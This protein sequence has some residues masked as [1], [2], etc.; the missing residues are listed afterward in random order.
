LQG[1]PLAGRDYVY[2]EQARDGI[3]T[4]TAMMTMVRS[5][6]WKLVH[7]LEHSDGEL[8]DLRADPGEHRNLW[9]IP[10]YRE[11]REEILGVLRDWLIQSNLRAGDWSAP[12]R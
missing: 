5:T 4:D 10:A 3:L 7:Y 12:W 6:E 11:K 8:Y 2:A 1:H 9:A